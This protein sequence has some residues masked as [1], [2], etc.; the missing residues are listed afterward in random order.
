MTRESKRIVESV[1]NVT[2]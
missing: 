2:L 1:N